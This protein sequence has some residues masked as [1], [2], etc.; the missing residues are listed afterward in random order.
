MKRSD[1]MI[2]IG[3]ALLGLLAA[4]Y[5][6]AVAPKREELSELDQEI[7]ALEASVAEQEQIAAFAEQAKADY[8]RDYH[9]LVVLGKAI[10]GDDD[11][12]SLIEQ[13]QSLAD[14]SQVDFRTIV[15]A[16]A[17]VETALPPAAQTTAESAPS[18]TPTSES[19]G[20]ASASGEAP[21]AGETTTAPAT[22]AAVPATETAA[23]ALPIGATVG[24]AG[25]PVLPYDLT[26]NGGFFEIADF[27]SELDG[28]VS[29]ESK[30]IGVDGRLITVDGFTLLGDQDKG[31]PHLSANLHVTTYVA[32]ADQGTTAGATETAPAPVPG[33]PVAPATPTTPTT[34]AA[35]GTVTP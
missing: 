17:P 30:G 22:P 25:L 26:F 27:M 11:S 7:A 18:G 19:E 29:I 24:S 15:L 9:R 14:R 8:D 10:P 13:T 34:T 21:A 28:M 32:P 2:V 3:I 31:F 35:P 33:V 6:L 20:E 23:A 1:R 12:A 5:F 16:A 4:F